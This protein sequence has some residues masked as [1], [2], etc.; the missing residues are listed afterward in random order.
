MGAAIHIRT[1]ITVMGQAST[2]GPH[3]TGIAAIEFTIHELDTIITGVGNKLAARFSKPAGENPAG[4][5]FFGDEGPAGAEG[6]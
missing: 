2:S 1:G 4:F 5:Y 6:D 3:F